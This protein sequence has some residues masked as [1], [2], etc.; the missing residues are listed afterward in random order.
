MDVAMFERAVE[1]TGRIVAGTSKEDMES[2]T[3]CTE[4]NVRDVLNHLIGGYES[5]AAAAGAEVQSSAATDYTAGDHV[6]AYEGATSKAVAAFA[7]PGAL[8]KTYKMGWGDTPGEVLLGLM[9]ADT[10]VHGWDLAKGTGQDTG[11]APELAEAIYGVTSSMLQPQGSFPRGPAFAEPVEV[12]DD[13]PI[14]D[15]M[16]A[17]LGRQP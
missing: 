1:A 16:L 12:P 17:Y 6:A 7:A 3:P 5:V 15:K 9:L 10:V 13:A 11:I 14:Q 4:W 8:E 2:S